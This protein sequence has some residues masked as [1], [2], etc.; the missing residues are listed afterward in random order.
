MREGGREEDEV[1]CYVVLDVICDMLCY[2]LC[3]VLYVICYVLC[4]ICRMVNIYG[5]FSFARR[6]WFDEEVTL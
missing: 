3:Y 6:S 4:V 2:M 1:I 5:T